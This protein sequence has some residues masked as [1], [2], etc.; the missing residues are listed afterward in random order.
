MFQWAKGLFGK[1][2]IRFIYQV[3][4]G[5]LFFP[6]FLISLKML[7]KNRKKAWILH[8]PLLFLTTLVYIIAFLRKRI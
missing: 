2:E 8:A 1:F 5:L 6:A 7:I 3:I 4:Y